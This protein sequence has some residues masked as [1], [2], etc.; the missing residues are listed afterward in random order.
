[1]CYVGSSSSSKPDVLLMA[2]GV[3][4]RCPEAAAEQRGGT[5]Q[6]LCMQA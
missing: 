5:G 1:M 2:G 3:A 4:G 6:V